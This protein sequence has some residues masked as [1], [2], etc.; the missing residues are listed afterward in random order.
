MKEA[1][2]NQQINSDKKEL[3]QKNIR[4]LTDFGFTW[5]EIAY[6]TKI[7][8][9]KIKTIGKGKPISNEI[10]IEVI[11]N[12]L[13]RLIERFGLNNSTQYSE[14]CLEDVFRLKL[15]VN[16]VALHKGTDDGQIYIQIGGV[17]AINKS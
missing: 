3:A 6:I 2:S 16:A 4:V 8:K 5:K 12:E 1:L 11:I 9:K 10:S 15:D 14:L 7:E 13:G 17:K